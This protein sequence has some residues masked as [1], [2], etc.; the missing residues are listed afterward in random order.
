[1]TRHFKKIL[2]TCGI[3]DLHFHTLR[4]NLR[5]LRGIGMQIKALSETAGTLYRSKITMDR[6]VH[7]SMSFKQSQITILQ[8]PD[9]ESKTPSQKVPENREDSGGIVLEKKILRYLFY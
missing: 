7:L 9:S 4:H 3:R 5:Q 8:F 1:M 6:Y 2:K